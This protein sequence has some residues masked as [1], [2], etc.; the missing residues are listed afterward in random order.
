MATDW[1]SIIARIDSAIATRIDGGLVDEYKIRGREIRYA[2]LPELQDLRDW[3]ARKLASTKGA[4]FA[5]GVPR[6]AG[7]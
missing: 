7:G 6:R 3:A 5:Y 4:P 1:A 2:S